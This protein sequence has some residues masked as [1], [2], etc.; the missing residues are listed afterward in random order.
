MPTKIDESGPAPA[1]SGKD[2]DDRWIESRLTQAE[3]RI[4]Q[5]KQQVISI[6]EAERKRISQDLHDDIGQRM[7]AIILALNNLRSGIPQYEPQLRGGIL[8]AIWQ[9]ED[10]MQQVRQLAYQLRP[11]NLESTT[12][13]RALQALCMVFAL[14]DQGRDLY[15]SDQE[16]PGSRLYQPTDKG[17]LDIDFSCVGSLPDIPDNQALA[18]YRFVQEALTNVARH[19]SATAVWVN[20]DLEEGDLT[21]SVEDDGAG[22]DPKSRPSGM[23]LQGICERFEMLNGSIEIDSFPGKGTRISG[24]LPLMTREIREQR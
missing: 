22:F 19:A 8:Q 16:R 3:A 14:Q 5:L 12:L 18:I 23:G 1:V 20:L 24:N 9:L 15:F 7:T 13:D 17:R 10:V 21:I 2:P 11:P 4:A 6:Q